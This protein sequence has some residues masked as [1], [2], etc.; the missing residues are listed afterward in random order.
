MLHLNEHQGVQQ[1][2]EDQGLSWDKVRQAWGC[3]G[4]RQGI[5]VLHKASVD[6]DSWTT[7]LR[8]Q[9]EVG[10]PGW[11]LRPKKHCGAPSPGLGLR[12]LGGS[13]DT[14]AGVNCE[15][16]QIQERQASCSAARTQAAWRRT[17]SLW[18][19]VCRKATESIQ[20]YLFFITEHTPLVE[21]WV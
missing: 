5:R 21:D 10:D 6:G 12:S 15:C 13:V 17:G 14:R 20:I 19:A 4:E 7:G 9:A 18:T 11:A 8:E 2:W 1:C 3:R 16:E